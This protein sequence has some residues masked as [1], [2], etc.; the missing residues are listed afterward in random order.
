MVSPKHQ[1][2]VRVY[3]F[4]QRFWAEVRITHV[5]LVP[6]AVISSVHLIMG[7]NLAL[8]ELK[9]HQSL[10]EMLNHKLVSSGKGENLP[11][12]SN[13][14]KTNPLRI[15]PQGERKSLNMRK[16]MNQVCR[17]GFLVILSPRRGW[18]GVAHISTGKHISPF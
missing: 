6:S 13:N 11:S 9:T 5:F 10:R 18:A 8:S 12:C 14:F 16:M 15:L 7:Y 4:L 3:A 2:K 1:S 17:K